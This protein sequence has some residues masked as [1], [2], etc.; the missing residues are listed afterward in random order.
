MMPLDDLLAL[1]SVLLILLLTITNQFSPTVQSTQKEEIL[2]TPVRTYSKDIIFCYGN[3]IECPSC[4]QSC[5]HS[6][7][8]F[9]YSPS[10]LY[11]KQQ[12]SDDHHYHVEH[13]SNR[14]RS[15]TYPF[16][17]APFRTVE[18]NSSIPT[19]HSP[20]AAPHCCR[21][22]NFFSVFVV[23]LLFVYFFRTQYAFGPFT[24]NLQPTKQNS[25]SCYSYLTDWPTMQANNYLSNL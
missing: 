2:F 10:I 16:T 11:S 17:E 4:Q 14:L 15:W 8:L 24:N 13:Y 6:G 19:N 21:H 5:C 23:Y 9:K 25:A 18:R 12:H 7:Y 1:I 20:T 3:C 22:R